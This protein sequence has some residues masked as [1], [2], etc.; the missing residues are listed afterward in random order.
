M[1]EFL[2][3]KLHLHQNQGGERLGRGDYRK[4]AVGNVYQ[5]YLPKMGFGRAEVLVYPFSLN[6]LAVCLLVGGIRVLFGSL[7]TFH[8]GGLGGAAILELSSPKQPSA[9]VTNFK[10]ISPS[11]YFPKKWCYPQLYFPACNEC[12]VGMGYSTIISYLPQ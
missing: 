3:S 8:Q 2:G 11:I 5:Q 1:I 10:Y 12:A 4:G 7:L 6:K 9:Q